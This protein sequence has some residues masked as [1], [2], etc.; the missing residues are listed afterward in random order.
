MNT[1]NAIQ[2]VK[3]RIVHQPEN[4]M[5]RLQIELAARVKT[6]SR[7]AGDQKSRDELLPVVLCT[8]RG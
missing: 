6:T 8:E 3:P 1:G 5:S 7:N 2:N 4:S